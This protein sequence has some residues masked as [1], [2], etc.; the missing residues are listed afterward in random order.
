[1]R[2]TPLGSP[3]CSHNIHFTPAD[4]HARRKKNQVIIL[5]QNYYTAK[6]LH[7]LCKAFLCQKRP[8]P[9]YRTPNRSCGELLL[10][11]ADDVF[12]TTSS[13]GWEKPIVTAFLWAAFV[14][15]VSPC[16]L[17]H[18]LLSVNARALWFATPLKK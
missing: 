3:P 2:D 10:A 11:Q 9:R 6:L 7:S 1:M 4:L 15:F 13:A 14:Y 12:G 18:H 5:L 8:P 17:T 16:Q